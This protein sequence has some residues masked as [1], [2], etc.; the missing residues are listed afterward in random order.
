MTE[1][2][3][4]ETVW[5]QAQSGYVD[6]SQWRAEGR[7]Q[8]LISYPPSTITE[9]RYGGT[10][11]GRGPYLAFPCE[12]WEVLREPFGENL[13]AQNFWKVVAVPVGD[14]DT[15]DQAHVDLVERL[16]TLKPDSISGPN[17]ADGNYMW[18]WRMSWPDGSTFIVDSLLERSS[19]PGPN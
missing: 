18:T 19:W 5:G 17:R 13:T 3:P 9:D 14:G 16:V 4:R 10:Y 2:L 6:L 8:R 15:P 11:G 7:I 1:I 12:P